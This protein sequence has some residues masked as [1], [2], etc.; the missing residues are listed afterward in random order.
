MYGCACP[1]RLGSA[2]THRPSPSS[3]DAYDYEYDHGHHRRRPD[4]QDVPARSTYLRV[5]T[6]LALAVRGAFDVCSRGAPCP[7]TPSPNA[8]HPAPS[9]ERLFSRVPPA[10][11]PTSCST[12]GVPRARG[13]ERQPGGVVWARPPNTEVAR[14]VRQRVRPHAHA[15]ARLDFGGAPEQAALPDPAASWRASAVMRASGD[16][17]CAPL[18]STRQQA[19]IAAARCLARASGIRVGQRSE[20]T[21]LRPERLLRV[22]CLRC[23]RR[24]QQQERR[25]QPR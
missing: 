14:P 15:H 20:R 21:E 16:H 6:D 7:R 22:R 24:L 17:T 5:F 19:S 9:R 8:A 23:A 12:P 1:L 4:G 11:Y 13:P 2:N 10:I 3:P 25:S 18:G